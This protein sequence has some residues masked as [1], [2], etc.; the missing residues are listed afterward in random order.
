MLSLSLLRRFTKPMISILR[1]WFTFLSR[2]RWVEKRIFMA[3]PRPVI[4]TFPLNLHLSQP[5]QSNI[6]EML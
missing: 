5:M 1:N 2:S 3:A 6:F 4:Y